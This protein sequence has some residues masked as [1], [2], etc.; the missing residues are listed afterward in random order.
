MALLSY[1]QPG[2]NAQVNLDPQRSEHY[3]LFGNKLWNASRFVVMHLW[4]ADESSSQSEALKR[5]QELSRGAL[6]C[7]MLAH[8]HNNGCS[9]VLIA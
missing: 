3:R 9:T 6:V 1:I 7:R 8:T 4:G 5:W 2:D